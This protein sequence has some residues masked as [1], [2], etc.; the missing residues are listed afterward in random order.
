[1]PEIY[2]T[3]T[4]A[5]GTPGIQ[6]PA[7]AVGAT[8]STGPQGPTGPSVTGPTGAKG[9]DAT[10]PQNLGT[11]DSPSFDKIY[12]TNNGNGTNVKVGDDT[13]LGDVNIENTLSVRGVEDSSKGYIS[14]GTGMVQ[15][16]GTDGSGKTV[17]GTDLIPASDNAYA[18][19]NS[20]HRWKSI[21]I[22]EGTIYITDATT[23][24]Q[25]AITIDN[26]VFLINGVAQAQLPAIVTNNIELHDGND[27]V[28]LRIVE[29]NG[30]G[31]I[32]FGGGSNGIYQ[33]G[34]KTY[35]NGI[36]YR[37]QSA[38][39]K[40][41]SYN[42]STGEI[43]YNS[44][45]KSVI[46]KSSVPAH[47]YGVSGDVEGMI[48]HDSS[49]LYVCIRDYVNNSTPIWKKIDYHAGDNW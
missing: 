43:S 21:S 41:L 12:V 7:G 35:I 28:V 20:E 38:G 2:Y 34:G 36:G 26:S 46:V 9:T 40:P 42:T 24:E 25:A 1:M 8:G 15:N 32:Y 3:R 29:E 48:A 10:L 31:K 39:I 19:G 22:G 23:G 18:L 33:D 44:D 6:G 16:I 37:A 14:F 27:N 30:V 5:S 4:G 47:S 49:F 45:I 13:W 11:S 17:I